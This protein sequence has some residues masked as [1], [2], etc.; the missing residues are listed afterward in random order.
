[1]RKKQADELREKEVIERYLKQQ[2]LE[3][4][5]DELLA[6]TGITSDPVQS[7][8][9]IQLPASLAPKPKPKLTLKTKTKTKPKPS[10]DDSEICLDIK[11]YLKIAQ[12][13]VKEGL[14]E[15]YTDTGD[16]IDVQCLMMNDNKIRLI[17]N[18]D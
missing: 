4:Q 15:V 17:I 12:Q 13:L 9:E 5:K 11:D 10:D 6:K 18:T 14:L 2:E 16:Q 7:K 3:K 8:S 1:M